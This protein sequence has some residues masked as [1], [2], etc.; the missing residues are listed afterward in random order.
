MADIKYPNSYWLGANLLTVNPRV[1]FNTIKSLIDKLNALSSTDDTLT[2]DTVSEKTASAGVTIDGALI[3]DGVF[4]GKQA[5]A[6]ATAAGLTTGALTGASQFV[7]VTSAGVNDVICLPLDST[8]PIGTVIEGWVGANGFELRMNATDSGAGIATINGVG[9]AV[10][11]AIPATT[12]FKVQKV[13]VRTWILTATT[14]LGAGVG[15][16]VPDAA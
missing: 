13:E 3:K 12:L 16:I 6:T 10:E 4:V 14:E 8:C 1:Y 5:T 9:G 2:V 11:A 7:T 15:A